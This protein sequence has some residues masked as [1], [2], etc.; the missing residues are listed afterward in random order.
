MQFWSKSLN[1][2][3]LTCLCRTWCMYYNSSC[4]CRGY[5]LCIH[6]VEGKIPS[7]I[8]LVSEFIVAH[9]SCNP[10]APVTSHVD[11]RIYYLNFLCLCTGLETLWYDV[12]DKAW[13]I[14]CLQCCWQPVESS[15]RYCYCKFYLISFFTCAAFALHFAISI[16]FSVFQPKHVRN[17][18]WLSF[19]RLQRKI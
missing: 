4:C 8:I 19:F 5:W 3:Y 13:F 11:Y 10:L 17:S 6:K 14:W 18:I 7:E 15:F 9:N 2:R 12:C 1:N 16:L